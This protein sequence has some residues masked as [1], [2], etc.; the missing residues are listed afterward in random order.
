MKNKFLLLFVTLT[1][2]HNTIKLTPPPFELNTKK[3]LSILFNKI[4]QCKKNKTKLKKETSHL[5]GC[6]CKNCI[7]YNKLNY[8]CSEYNSQENEGTVYIAVSKN[9]DKWITINVKNDS[10]KHTY[11]IE[12]LIQPIIKIGFIDNI[13]NYFISQPCELEQLLYKDA[14]KKYYCN[15]LIDMQLDINTKCEKG[16]HLR[17]QSLTCKTNISKEQFEKIHD[18]WKKQKKQKRVIKNL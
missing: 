14:T 18:E 8:G 4:N 12:T 11:L 17:L 1:L 5:F 9:P 15:E 3:I 6:C 2:N 10:K 16:Y 13:I 7:E